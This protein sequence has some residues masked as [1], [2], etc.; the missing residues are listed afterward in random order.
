[1]TLAVIGRG[2]MGQ[3][4]AEVARERGHRV[5]LQLGSRDNAHGA[6]LGAAALAGIDVALEFTTPEAA[7]AN[8]ERCLEGGVSVVSGTTGWAGGERTARLA[9]LA[10]RRGAALVLAPNFA[11]GVLLFRRLVQRAAEL[12]AGDELL[13]LWIEEAHHRGKRDAPS[14]TALALAHDVLARLPR[15]QVLRTAAP[16]AGGAARPEELVLVSARGGS[17]PG[18]HRVV[19]DA[20]DE[21]I[22]LVH[23]VRSRRVFAL[24]A[25]RAAEA[26]GGRTG[27]VELEHLLL[28]EGS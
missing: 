19:V 4:V 10:E 7:P 5:A 12:V 1:L 3:L 17:E 22:E 13:D 11:L 6:G 14:G 24:G 9:E 23:R 2:R 18:L 21:T 26:L 20:P 27:L 28:P 15:K 16:E 25:L 8:V